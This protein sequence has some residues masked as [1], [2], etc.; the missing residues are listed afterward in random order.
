MTPRPVT[1]APHPT[2]SSPSTAPR[3][4]STPRTLSRL[5]ASGT[6]LGALVL[7]GCGTSDALVGLHPA[8]AEQ[9]A[10]APLDAEGATAVAARLLAARD[11]PV[12]GDAKA[13]KAARAEVLT[14]DALRVAEAQAAR[15]G[16]QP[17][18]TE[19]APAAKPTI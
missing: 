19:L 6:L 8:P 4:P 13:A 18:T 15:A 10:A 17:A 3:T 11:A 1:T 9:T 12:E 14:G 16:T 7:A 5:V 2:T